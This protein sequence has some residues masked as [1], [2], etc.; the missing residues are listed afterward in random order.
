M[1]VSAEQ[2]ARHQELASATLERGTEKEKTE[3]TYT[4]VLPPYDHQRRAV[5]IA[6]DRAGYGF[7]MEMGT[8]KSKVF[9]D[10]A[11]PLYDKGMRR[12]VV[13]APKGMYANWPNIEI[14]KHTPDF[15]REK[16]IVHMWEGGGS[17]K[18]QRALQR[19]LEKGDGAIRVLV[20]NIEA[21]SASQRAVKF[22]QEFMA[23]EPCIIGVDESSTIKNPSAARTKTLLKLRDLARWR[24]I[25]TGTP[26]TRDPLDLFSQF[27]FLYPQCLGERNFFAFR[28]RYAV[29]EEKNFGGRK[30][31]IP[32]S[33]RDVEHLGRIVRT[34]SFVATKEECLDL[35]PK[36]YQ[37]RYVEMT[38][39]QERMYHSLKEYCVAQIG[40]D[41][42]VSATVVITQILRLYQILLGRAVDEEGGT[43]HIPT[44]R[45]EGVDAIIDETSGKIIW[46]CSYRDDVSVLV[47][48]L[49]RRGR[50]VVQYDGGVD[51]EGRA[52][53][54]EEFQNGA[55]DDFVGTVHTGG[56]G[57]TLTAARTVVYFSNSPDAEKRWQSEDRAHRIGQT[58]SVLYI[59]LVVK[60]TVEEK[61]IALLKKKKS[62]S[63]SVMVEQEL[64]HLLV[65]P[66]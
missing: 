40:T 23:G 66:D 34:H 26:L 4:P 31:Q 65:G 24:R 38:E 53:A 51:R 15:Y 1:A 6:G 33:F 52:D 18:E 29:L 32:V 3:V 9:L 10:N 44:R 48:H 45:M 50:R 47:E 57:I 22:L 59:D 11:L 30:V 37:T 8:G 7:L 13:L 60:G 43:T 41:T 36:V 27:E 55:A 54:V 19:M 42:F 14:P 28:R 46:W 61:F 21:V 20:M 17:A 12:I 63:D 58:G 5:D 2:R 49:R 56:Y 16:M 25:M 35:P 62:L 39:Q 64:R